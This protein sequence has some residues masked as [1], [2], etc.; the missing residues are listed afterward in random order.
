MLCAIE[1][2]LIGTGVFALPLGRCHRSHSSTHRSYDK[3]A[4][5]KPG[6]PRGMLARGAETGGLY[7]DL[8]ASRFW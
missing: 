3:T 1:A 6:Q 4:A 8:I 5:T 2:K 7:E